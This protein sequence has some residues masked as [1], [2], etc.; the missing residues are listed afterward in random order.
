VIV[1]QHLQERADLRALGDLLFAHGF[2]D[3]EGRF[4]DACDNA[5]SVLSLFG[6]V[7][8]VLENDSL[9][10]CKTTVEDKHNFA[11]LE[12]AMSRKSTETFI[13]LDHGG[14]L[15]DKNFDQN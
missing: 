6:A 14:W 13:Q 5:M 1:V 12:T 11:W 9:L 15:I 4:L 7:I 2:G 3:L 10:A 8:E